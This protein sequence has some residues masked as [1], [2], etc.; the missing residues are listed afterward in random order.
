MVNMKTL[1]ALFA[2][3]ALSACMTMDGV[4]VRNINDQ[5]TVK[6]ST[7]VL[8]AEKLPAPTVLVLHGC[9]GVDQHHQEWARQLQ[10]WGYN[11]VIV[12]SFRP[13][14]VSSVCTNVTRVTSL[15]RSVDA[16][17][18]AK[19]VQ[20]QNWSTQN[21]GAIGFSHGGNTAVDIAVKEHYTR[22]VGESYIKASVS[23]YPYCAY[24]YYFYNTGIPLQIHIGLSDDWTPANL[25][26]DL[27]RKW[28][29]GENFFT[30][31]NAYHG[32][33]RVGANFTVMGTS[34]MADLKPRVLQYNPEANALTRQRTKVFFDAH[35]R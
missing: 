34:T 19:W 12:D 26:V 20:Q 24:H 14:F 5:S 33:D 22:E 9:G 21:V 17:M 1:V 7:Q 32:Y 28:N 11:A 8:L 16:H 10:Q 30:Y 13:R 35:L 18:V 23:L 2:P 29:L 25:C 4:E 27:S 3:L 31:P 15:Q 6:V